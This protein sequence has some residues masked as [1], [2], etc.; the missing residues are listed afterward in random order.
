MGFQGKCRTEE[1]DNNASKR[2]ASAQRTSKV[3]E[4]S[5]STSK[6]Q[7]E[8]LSKTGKLTGE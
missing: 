6:C 4:L 5:N 2:S 1:M 3:S 7:Y 8:R